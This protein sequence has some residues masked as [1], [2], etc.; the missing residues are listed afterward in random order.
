MATRKA[1]DSNLSGKKYND[2][3]AGGTKI[4]DLPDAPT[5]G[6]AS[7]AQATSIDIAFTPAGT[8]GLVTTYRALSTPGSI[9]TTSSSSPITVTGLTPLTSYAFQVRAE[10]S[11]GNSAYSQASTALSTTAVPVTGSYDALAV[12]TVPSGGASSITFA[13]IPQS[14]YQHL[15]I[16][17]IARATSGSQ[18]AGTLQLN[19]DTAANYSY[20][21]LFGNSSSMTN[22]GGANST[23]MYYQK[24]PGSSDASNV[25]GCFIID[26]FDYLSTSKN[27]TIRYLGGDDLNG[28]GFVFLG[29]NAWYNTSAI[30][31]IKVAVDGSN[32]AQYSQFALYGIRG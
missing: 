17:G 22:N 5:I 30:T 14:G 20:H 27:K 12:Y 10:N 15:Q 24:V 11:S 1:S 23:I 16:R 26:I 19:S 29:S 7:N 32:L 3:S 4:A 25:Y 21:Q 6:S 9:Q 2:A 8:G 28:S 18:N 31:S 13:G